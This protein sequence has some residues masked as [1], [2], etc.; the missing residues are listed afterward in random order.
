MNQWGLTRADTGTRAQAVQ[1]EMFASGHH[2][3]FEGGLK[4]RPGLEL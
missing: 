2:F 3:T 1:N 4:L